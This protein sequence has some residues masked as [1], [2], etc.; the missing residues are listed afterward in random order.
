MSEVS[1]RV[2]NP[3]PTAVPLDYEQREEPI[4]VY[5]G[6]LELRD[7]GQPVASA[8]GRVV[9]SWLPNP[10]VR[11]VLPGQELFSFSG[12]TSLWIAELGIDAN[13]LLTHWGVPRVDITGTLN[14]ADFPAT[15]AIH[16]LR[17][18]VPN[19]LLLRRGEPL[20]AD[21]H[22]WAGRNVLTA[23]EWQ[24][25]LDER[26][27]G[28]A[29]RARLKECSGHEVTHTAQLRRR[30]GAA[31][32]DTEARDKLLAL[33][34]FFGLTR[35]LWAPPLLAHGFDASGHTVWHDWQP[36]T[37]SPWRGVMNVIDVYHPESLEEAFA[38]FLRA[39]A[40]EVWHEPLLFA[41]QMYVEANG[42][43]YAETSLVLTQA[44][45][46]LIAWVHFVD[47]EQSYSGPDFDKLKYGA[48][49][50]IRKLL[51]W[52]QLDPAIPSQL[53]ALT[54]E[55]ARLDWVD[56][57]HAIDALRNAL[58]HPDKRARIEG[59]DLSARIDLHELALWYTEL[60]LLRVLM[61]NGDYSSRLASRSSGDVKPVP[62][63]PP[64]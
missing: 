45:L 13:V 39:W 25:T 24:L 60:A 18:L 16:E 4:T 41:T 26:P 63:A 17:F 20:E 49:A 34:H 51:D 35:G 53:T 2:P 1:A 11:F 55:A 12:D 21:G 48:A 37:T 22:Y 46:E 47:D 23:D 19:Y 62:W 52:M 3:A 10:G 8:S 14:R 32:S 61:F 59:T 40:D 64:V 28:S 31:F 29:V 42:P 57:P 38:G 54:A 30:D 43:V 50:R 9:F 36:P 5:A 6:T 58:I 15:D 33:A 27:D 56:G 7:D 44:A